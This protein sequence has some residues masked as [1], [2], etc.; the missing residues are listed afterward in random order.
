M[1]IIQGGLRRGPL[2]PACGSAHARNGRGCH[3]RTESVNATLRTAKRCKQIMFTKCSERTPN[4][5][6]HT[7]P[8]FVPV[9]TAAALHTTR[10]V[11]ATAAAESAATTATYV[12]TTAPALLVRM[13]TSTAIS[14]IGS[15]TISG[16]THKYSTDIYMMALRFVQ[17]QARSGNKQ[18]SPSAI[19]SR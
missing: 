9:C 11:A 7:L 18:S 16:K 12:Y 8:L 19:Y 6:K 10:C 17:Q 3:T 5:K 1:Y 2:T 15:T 13:S 4:I 14:S